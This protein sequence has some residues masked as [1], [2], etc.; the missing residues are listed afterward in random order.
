MAGGSSQTDFMDEA[1]SRAIDGVFEQFMIWFADPD[2]AGRNSDVADMLAAQFGDVGWAVSESSMETYKD[3]MARRLADTTDG[4]PL[5]AEFKEQFA[6]GG[7]DKAAAGLVDWLADKMAV[8]GWADHTVPEYDPASGA[9]YRYD[10]VSGVYEW[11]DPH[12]PGSW[13]SHEE[14]S[15]LQVDGDVAEHERYSAPEFDAE[16]QHWYRYDHATDTY[17]WA[18]GDQ[19]AEPDPAAWASAAEAAQY[20]ADADQLHHAA[21]EADEVVAT[22]APDGTAIEPGPDQPALTPEAAESVRMVRELVVQPSVD[23]V[24]AKLPAEL[25]ERLGNEELQDLVRR[26]VARETARSLQPEATA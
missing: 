25:T 12:T 6:Q 20:S 18:A 15:A 24:M 21:A 9:W 22:A 23:E 11:E 14:S 2:I 17:Q 4:Q 7:G 5:L 16:S 19:A 1:D 26:L 8:N 10:L 3:V 13:L